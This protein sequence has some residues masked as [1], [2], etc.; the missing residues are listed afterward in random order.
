M[1][2]FV[3]GGTGFIGS[4]FL[5]QALAAGHEVVALRR[6]GSRAVIS[7]PTE[8]EWVSGDLE[9]IPDGALQGC[10]CLVHFASHG[11]TDPAGA[12]WEDCFRWNVS[13]SLKLWLKAADAGL[14]RFVICGSCFEYGKSGERY[15]FIPTTAPLEPTASYHA[16]KAAATAAAFGLCIDK[17]IEMAILRPFH[18]FGE[19]EGMGRFWPSLRRAALAGEDFPMSEGTQ[20]RD[21]T[22]VVDVAAEFLRHASEESLEVAQPLVR[23]IGRGV[24][25]S[26]AEFATEQWQK[27]GG[28]GALLKGAVPMRRNET[29]RFVPLL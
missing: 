16:S 29:M 6:E 20:I 15:E 26:L 23:N 10:D 2:I 1:R 22:D 17:Q 14:K 3:T 11:V 13:A 7:L 25:Q 21:F 24:P 9:Q 18:V 19:G 27:F 4:H 5:L 12:T 28:T 8:P